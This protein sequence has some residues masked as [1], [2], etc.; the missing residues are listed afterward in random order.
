VW[1]KIRA[2][3]WK[4]DR[5]MIRT[6]KKCDGNLTTNRKEIAQLLADQFKVTSSDSNYS[7][8]FIELKR[9]EELQTLVRRIQLA[10]FPK[11]KWS[12][13]YRHANVFSLDD[14]PYEMLKQ[15]PRVAKIKILD[16]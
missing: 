11:Q 16:I 5:K 3:S 6:L 4:N 7:A 2:I 15:L 1:G 14:V 9:R 12:M 8:D 10:L 13:R